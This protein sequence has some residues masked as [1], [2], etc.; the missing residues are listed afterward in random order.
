[1]T[2]H[3]TFYSENFFSASSGS[4]DVRGLWAMNKWLRAIGAQNAAAISSLLVDYGCISLYSRFDDEMRYLSFRRAY[5]PDLD[6]FVRRAEGIDASTEK[7][8]A[9]YQV[10]Y[11]KLG[12]DQK[13]GEEEGD[14]FV[15]E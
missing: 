4:K 2:G 11:G 5:G 7:R 6:I 12:K 3:K 1:M 9:W 13:I 10:S 14:W 15:L 8:R